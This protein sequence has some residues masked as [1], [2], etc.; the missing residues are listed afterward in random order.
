MAEGQSETKPLCFAS[1]PSTFE[2][3]HH[4]ANRNS[5]PSH[6]CPN[7]QAGQGSVSAP[8]P[9]PQAETSQEAPAE[10]LSNSLSKVDEATAP[11]KRN[12]KRNGK[13][14]GNLDTQD[15]PTF[16]DLFGINSDSWTR[17]FVLNGT[18]DLD[19]VDIHE[20][21][22]KKLKDD[23]DCI[24]RR[25]GSVMMDAKTRR[26]A[27]EVEKL[28]KIQNKDVNTARDLRLNSIR[29]TIVVPLSEFKNEENLEERIQGHLQ[30]Q[31]IPVSNVTVF[32]K[33]SRKGNTLTCACITFESRSIPASVRVGFEKV[34]VKEDI[35]KPRQCH[36][37]WK[38]G[39]AKKHC[40]GIPCCPICGTLTHTLQ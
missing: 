22:N 13:Q 2:V 29:G 27:I 20:E 19:N 38:L 21:L 30:Q 8:V 34:K 35:P 12:R 1:P 6:P 40:E 4:G 5:D 14:K 25:D 36:T 26:N 7:G 17:F 28:Q 24:R 23:F 39:H 10:A 15:H 33:N 31:N 18:G 3:D 32:K 37:C 16:E 9:K 11:L